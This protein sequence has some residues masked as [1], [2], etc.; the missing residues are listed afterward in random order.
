MSTSISDVWV[1]LF[2]ENC[3]LLVLHFY[4]MAGSAVCKVV[5]RSRISEPQLHDL[6]TGQFSVDIEA[7]ANSMRISCS[8]DFKDVLNS[9]DGREWEYPYDSKQ[10]LYLLVSITL[11]RHYRGV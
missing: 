3:L 6:P 2:L 7:I 9:N 5:G 11:S 8:A 1:A 4:K 10:N